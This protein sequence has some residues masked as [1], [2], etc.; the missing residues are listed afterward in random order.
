MKCTQVHAEAETSSPRL[1]GSLLV[2]HLD[3]T[4]TLLANARAF[5]AYIRLFRI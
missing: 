2:L 5:Q 1:R 4:E 3:F